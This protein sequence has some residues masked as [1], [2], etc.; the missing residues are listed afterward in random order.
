MKEKGN[1]KVRGEDGTQLD[2]GGL[3]SSG[4]YRQ[5]SGKTTGAGC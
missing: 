3:G 2:L 5:Y 4:E 1:E